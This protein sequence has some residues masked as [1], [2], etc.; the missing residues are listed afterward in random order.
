MLNCNRIL[1]GLRV[2]VWISSKGSVDHS[3]A[4]VNEERHDWLILSTV[5]RNI[6]WLSSS[7]SV[8]TSM[9]L[10]VYWLLSISPISIV[11][12]LEWHFGW[13]SSQDCVVEIWAILQHFEHPWLH[14]KNTLSV[15]EHTLSK[16]SVDEVGQIYIYKY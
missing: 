10:M 1:R 13:S 16:T 8:G 4:I 9:V 15:A 5:P 12:A 11:S 6:S 2:G 7:V 3:C 14:H